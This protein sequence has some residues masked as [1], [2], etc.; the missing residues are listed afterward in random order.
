MTPKVILVTG[1][2]RARTQAPLEELQ[3]RYVNR[4]QYIAGDV[5]DPSLIQKAISLAID[6]HG[7]LDG[8]VLNHGIMTVERIVDS[9]PENWT[10][11]MNIRNAIPHLRA[12]KGRIVL[13]SSGASMH[14]YEGWGAYGASKA[15]LNHLGMTLGEEEKDIIT[16]TIRPGVVDTQMQVDLRETFGDLLAEK[17]QEKFR[18]LK[19]DG[20]LL[21]PEQPGNVI[22]KV[23]LEGGRGL[24]GRFFR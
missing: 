21:R 15:A 20:R 24:S 19:R 4:V 13:V 23:V 6:K 1:A 9:S 2:S 5:S 16:V 7:R 11:I 14:A 12:S 22:A 10:R 3:Q 18:G 8:L 17:D